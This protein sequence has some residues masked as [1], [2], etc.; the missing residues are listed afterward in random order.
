MC[1]SAGNS[2]SLYI[3]FILKINFGIHTCEK[4]LSKHCRSDL[5]MG[6]FCIES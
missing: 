6:S 3:I 5:P 2:F 1:T 4:T